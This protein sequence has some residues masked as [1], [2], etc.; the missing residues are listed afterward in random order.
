MLCSHLRRYLAVIICP[1]CPLRIAAGLRA[2]AALSVYKRVLPLIMMGLAVFSSGCGSAGIKVAAELWRA[3]IGTP[4]LAA[5]VVANGLL[6]T[7]VAGK[8]VATGSALAASTDFWHIGSSS[9]TMT[10]SLA[11]GLVA[12]NLTRRNLTI[13]EAFSDF[14]D[15][16]PEYRAV[17]LE[18]LLAHRSGLPG[19]DEP[20]EAV[21]V[22]Q[23][24]R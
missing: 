1:L 16:E 10:A 19:F 8:R 14:T 12:R 18:E 9:K 6:Y 7:G 13:G 22:P 2:A 24:R 11:G 20:E 3:K 5:G 17:T 15:I 21:S 23:V 4:G